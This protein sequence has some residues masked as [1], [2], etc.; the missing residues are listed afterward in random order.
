MAST[1]LTNRSNS[2]EKFLWCVVGKLLRKFIYDLIGTQHKGT[3]VI[4]LH[5]SSMSS[6]FELV[7]MYLYCYILERPKPASCRGW[8]R[9]RGVG[10][11]RG[12]RRRVRRGHGWRRAAAAATAPAHDATA[13]AE[14]AADASDAPATATGSV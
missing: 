9:R 8:C 1:Y 10:G 12:R 5:F 6:S 7:V 11:W 14:A 4:T 2:T 3:L 13:A